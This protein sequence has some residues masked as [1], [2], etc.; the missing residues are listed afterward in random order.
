MVQRVKNHPSGL[1]ACLAFAMV[2]ASC[3]H[4]STLSS[5]RSQVQPFTQ[6][7]TQ[8][9][10]VVRSARSDL[11]A[12]GINDL[13]VKYAALQSRANDYVGLMVEAITTGSLDAQKNREDADELAKA[14]D[15]FNG[16]LKP[17]VT[18]QVPGQSAPATKVPLP[19]PDQWVAAMQN[20]LA[21]SWPQ[22]QQQLSSMS[23]Q[24]RTVLAEQLKHQ[25]AWPDFQYIGQ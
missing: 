2:L 20:Q 22:Y 15:G 16:S 1:L 23:A 17:L 25:L 8:S 24:Q 12:Q 13:N 6:A 5:L 10:Q 11:G 9:I 14:I 4:Q 7:R 18:P 3:A 21:A 19:L